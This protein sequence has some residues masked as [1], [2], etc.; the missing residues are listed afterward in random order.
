MGR[1]EE[2]CCLAEQSELWD[3]MLGPSGM[4]VVSQALCTCT[5]AWSKYSLLCFSSSKSDVATHYL[6]CKIACCV[7]VAVSH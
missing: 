2:Q 1:E 4:L 5:A 6:A 7:G 3:V